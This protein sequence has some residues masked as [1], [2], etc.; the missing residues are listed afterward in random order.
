MELGRKGMNTQ[1]T[2][3]QDNVTML[4]STV[5]VGTLNFT[6]DKTQRTAQHKERILT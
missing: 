6:F 2:D 4:Y 5:I 1:D 3:L